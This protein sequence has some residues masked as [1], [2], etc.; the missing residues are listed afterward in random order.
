M[1]LP[2]CHFSFHNIEGDL[3]PYSKWHGE[4]FAIVA[5]RL[6]VSICSSTDKTS[7]LYILSHKM[8]A[9]ELSFNLQLDVITVFVTSISRQNFD[10]SGKEG[11]FL[12][13]LLVIIRKT[14][15]SVCGSTPQNV[16]LQFFLLPQVVPSPALS[17]KKERKTDQQWPCFYR[18]I[19]SVNCD[20]KGYEIRTLSVWPK[21]LC[22]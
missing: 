6:T 8:L 12:T 13:P 16:I 15:L 2:S 3:S 14:I 1:C 11:P 20:P 4:S 7:W 18:G 9:T 5:L 22:N 19:Q 17:N 10:I 21:K